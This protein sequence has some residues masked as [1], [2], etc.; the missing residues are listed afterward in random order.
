MIFDNRPFLDSGG[1]MKFNRKLLLLIILG[2]LGITVACNLPVFTTPEPFVFPTP[3]MTMTALFAPTLVPPTDTA[4]PATATPNPTET[5]LPTATATNPPPSATPTN[6]AIPPTAIPPSHRSSP[7]IEA[8]YVKH[9]PTLD[10]GWG[11][12]VATEYSADYIVWGDENWKNSDDLSSS[13]MVEWD[14]DYLYVAWKVIDDKYVQ[15][16]TGDEIYLGDSV[17]VLLDTFVQ[18]DY[19][20]QYIDWDDFQIGVSPGKTT[21]G[22][23]PQSYI[24]YPNNKTGSTTKVII[25]TKAIGDGYRVTIGIPWKTLDVT[26]FT[27]AHYGFAASVSDDDSKHGG[28]QQSM[29]S[30]SPYR[31]LTDPTTWGDLVLVK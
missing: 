8:Q 30:S 9:R 31:I 15:I 16:S 20:Y 13:I 4:V 11:D 27:G 1:R 3:D 14:E 19:W 18:A 6:T 22:N 17:E 21:V 25:G 24:W 5:P 12:W 7:R 28:E 10:G 2:I 23:K 29:V 26:P